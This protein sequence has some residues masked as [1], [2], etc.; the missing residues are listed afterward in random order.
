MNLW[1][2]ISGFL[3]FGPHG[4]KSTNSQKTNKLTNSLIIDSECFL[5]AYSINFY[6]FFP[7][8]MFTTVQECSLNKD[9]IFK[10]LGTEKLII[11]TDLNIVLFNLYGGPTVKI[12]LFSVLYIF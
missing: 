12:A 4:I 9:S 1:M 8:S 5:L 11:S 3:R 2:N 10:E 6:I 7:F